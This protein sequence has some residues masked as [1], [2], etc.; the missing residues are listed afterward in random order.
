MH[1]GIIN[2]LLTIILLASLLASLL[3]YLYKNVHICTCSLLFPY[4]SLIAY[5]KKLLKSTVNFAVFV[6]YDRCFPELQEKSTGIPRTTGGA[7]FRGDSV[8]RVVSVVQGCSIMYIYSN[9]DMFEFM[10]PVVGEGGAP[11]DVQKS[12][13]WVMVTE[14]IV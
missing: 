5:Y 8:S 2:I 13:N 10:V 3:M 7:H 9:V 4:N 12:T 14:M 11:V 6:C 1:N